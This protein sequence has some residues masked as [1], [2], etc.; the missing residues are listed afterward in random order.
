M[1]CFDRVPGA[2]ARATIWRLFRDLSRRRCQTPTNRAP[3]NLQKPERAS[4]TSS[5]AKLPFL[6]G[7]C[8]RAAPLIARCNHRPID[9]IDSRIVFGCP[10]GMASFPFVLCQP[11]HHVV[12]Q[13]CFRYSPALGQDELHD[14]AVE[15]SFFSFEHRHF[16]QPCSSYQEEIGHGPKGSLKM[17]KQSGYLVGCQIINHPISRPRDQFHSR[18]GISRYALLFD[19]AFQHVSQRGDFQLDRALGNVF[20]RTLLIRPLRSRQGL[21]LPGVPRADPGVRHYRTGLLP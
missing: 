13:G 21:R 5:G 17:L 4:W 3:P 14:P 1:V 19:S 8:P 10:K 6:S 2:L 20:S 12:A 15:I 16:S 18:E 7:T 11:G 9:V